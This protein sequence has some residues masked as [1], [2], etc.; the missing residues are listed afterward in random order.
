MQVLDD[1]LEFL[2]V[3]RLPD[4]LVDFRVDV[5]DGFETPQK[6]LVGHY[7]PRVH[8]ETTQQF[9]KEQGVL[10]NPLDRLDEK[11]PQLQP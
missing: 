2:P 9:A 1:L 6:L 10:A 5:F 3:F 7:V 4:P 8:V 11:R